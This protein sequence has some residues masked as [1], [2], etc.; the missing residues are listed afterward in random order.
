MTHLPLALEKAFI[1]TVHD[2][3]VFQTEMVTKIEDALLFEEHIDS[4]VFRVV[5]G[6]D[7]DS[8]KD[9]Y[10]PV[11]TERDYF[12]K[13]YDHC[14]ELIRVLQNFYAIYR[15]VTTLH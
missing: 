5:C 15:G 8:W 1:I 13:G 14:V 11:N 6:V 3:Y 9:I 2:A 7:S 12:S 10:V 4:F